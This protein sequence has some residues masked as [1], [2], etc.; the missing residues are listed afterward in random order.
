[1]S[2]YPHIHTETAFICSSKPL[3]TVSTHTPGTERLLNQQCHHTISVDW[4]L[5][6]CGAKC[7]SAVSPIIA[8]SLSCG[9]TFLCLWVIH[10]RSCLSVCVHVCSSLLVWCLCVWGEMGCQL[11]C[12]GNGEHVWLWQTGVLDDRTQYWRSCTHTHAHWPNAYIKQ[13]DWTRAE[14]YEK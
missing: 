5:G 9:D 1:M 10:L 12:H 8:N 3:Y 2:V 6:W 14:L 11:V 7:Q 4:L 13:R